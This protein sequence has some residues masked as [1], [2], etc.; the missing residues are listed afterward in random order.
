MIDTDIFIQY[1]G[2]LRNKCPF[3]ITDRDRLIARLNIAATMVCCSISFSI[4]SLT[5]DQHQILPAQ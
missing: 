2:L 5:S 3:N 1:S 4:S